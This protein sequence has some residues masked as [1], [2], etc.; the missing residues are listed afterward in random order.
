[1]A[2]I[3]EALLSNDD[4]ERQVK[5]I[6]EILETTEKTVRKKVGGRWDY[7][8]KARIE[9]QNWFMMVYDRIKTKPAYGRF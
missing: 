6:E 1:M 9:K 3:M 4:G 5:L 2:L 7:S 8:K